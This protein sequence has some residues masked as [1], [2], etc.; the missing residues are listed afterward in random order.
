MTYK[1]LVPGKKYT[2]KAKLISKKDG[3]TVLGEGSA[4]LTP[5]ESAGE[6][7]VEITVNEKADPAVDAAVA[8]EKLVSTEVDKD[9]N[10]TTGSSDENDIATH[11]HNIDEKQTLNTKRTPSIQK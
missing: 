4:E 7:K 11:E 8:F 10:E 5:T 2:L 3:E 1:D 9:G 6:Q